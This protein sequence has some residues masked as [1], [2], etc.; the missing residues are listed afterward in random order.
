VV[1]TAVTA[2][3]ITEARSASSIRA[4]SRSA[5]YH[6]RLRSLSVGRLGNNPGLKESRS[7][8]TGGR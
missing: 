3:T 7:R 4:S 1:T 8:Y 2:A 5:R 6:L